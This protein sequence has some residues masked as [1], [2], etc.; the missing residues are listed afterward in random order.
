MTDFL[1]QD[2]DF[3]EAIGAFII[4]FSELEYGLAII[5]TLTE[6]DLRK[7]DTSYLKYLGY[8]FELKVKTITE[9]V[10]KNLIELRQ[11]WDDIK[12]KI[13]NVN[14]ERRFLAHGFHNYFLPKDHISTRI[15]ENGKIVEKKQTLPDIKKLINQL[16]H[17]NTGEN[18]I[19][20]EF[21]I[22]FTTLRIDKWNALVNDDYKM[23]YSVNSKIVSDWKG[24]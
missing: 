6:F 17:L 2:K 7:K 4:A 12:I 23:V 19:N 14:R 5:C 9:F 3:K 20:G 13:G 10:N 22:A 8:S 1:K 15:K 16:H 24:K 21:Y 18:G 11:I